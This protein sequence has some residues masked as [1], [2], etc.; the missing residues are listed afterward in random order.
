MH[1]RRAS[2]RLLL[3]FL[4]LFLLNGLEVAAISILEREKLFAIL[5]PVFKP[6]LTLN[7]SKALIYIKKVQNWRWWYSKNDSGYLHS[8][9]SKC[10]LIIKYG[11]KE[12]LFSWLLECHLCSTFLKTLKR[13]WFLNIFPGHPSFRKPGKIHL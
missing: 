1:L 10:W 12:I 7:I 9:F 4:F 13:C 11:F 3:T 8:R 6:N 2:F 5:K